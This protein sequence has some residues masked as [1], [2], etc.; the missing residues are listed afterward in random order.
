MKEAILRA[1]NLTPCCLAITTKDC[2]CRNVEVSKLNSIVVFGIIV[3]M[4]FA[5]TGGSSGGI[6]VL[7]SCVSNFTNIVSEGMVLATGVNS[8]GGMIKVK[9]F[10]IES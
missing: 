3:W 5:S 7:S 4:N 10:R 8:V 2:K 9:T 1:R 6:L